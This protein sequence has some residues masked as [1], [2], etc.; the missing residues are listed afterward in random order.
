LALVVQRLRVVQHASAKPAHTLCWPVAE[1]HM[2]NWRAIEGTPFPLG[3]TW[4]P[5]D[6]AYNFAILSTTA[7]AIRLRLFAEGDLV[8]PVFALNLDPLTNKSDNTW[9]CRVFAAAAAGKA[10]YYSLQADSDPAVTGAGTLFTLGTELLDPYARE[11]FFPPN[12]RLGG[13]PGQAALS[14]LPSQNPVTFDWGNAPWPLRGADLLIY[15]LHVRGFTK[16]PNSGVSSDHAGTYLGVIDKIPYLQQLGIT[17]VELM[18]VFCFDPVSGGSWGYMPISVFYPHPAYATAPERAVDEFRQMVRALHEAGIEVILDVVFNHTAEGN[19]QGPAYGLK[20]LDNTG[21]YLTTGTPPRGYQDYSGCGNSLDASSPITRRLIL[22]AL[23]YWVS[24][25]HVDGFR[26][27]LAAVL[28]RNPDGSFDLTTPPIFAELASDPELADTRFIAE[29]WDA[30]GGYLIGRDFPG[31][32]WMQWNDHYRGQLRGFVRGDM[33]LVPSVMTRLYGSDDLFP[34]DAVSARH[35]WQSVNYIVSHDGYTLYDQVAYNGDG[36]QSSWNCGVEG[37]ANATAD[38]LVLRRRQVRNFLTLLLMSNGTP[39]IRMGDEFLQTQGGNANPYNIDDVTTWLDWSKVTANV[40]MLRFARMLIA[41][42]NNHPA[43]C[44]SRFWR[45]D[46]S[47]YGPAG[48]PDL[49]TVSHTI[50]YVIHGASVQDKDIYVMANMYWQDVSF[51]MQEPGPWNRVIDTGR[52]SPDDIGAPV[53][54]L[55]PTVLVNARSVVVAV[56]T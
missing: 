49:S 14:V 2:D 24:E 8:N 27:D 15:E 32:N 47:W 52:V 55:G 19:Q 56:S 33:G 5:A 30:G 16:N 39:M 9:H 40:E 48:R 37:D 41:F 10:R 36:S 17:A 20:A 25:M 28:A 31:L 34:G 22:D 7:T 38:V 1:H 3:C 4:V 43:I 44:R 6:R 51:T 11:V 13:P 42:R 45:T 54:M 18:P 26:F 53:P 35:P 21:Y 12:F 23:R 29:P 50:A 46:V